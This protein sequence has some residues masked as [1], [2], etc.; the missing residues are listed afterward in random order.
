MKRH[1]VLTEEGK[2]PAGTH[3]QRFV[4]TKDDALVVV[5]ADNIKWIREAVDDVQE[6]LDELNRR[7]DSVI[8]ETRGEVHPEEDDVGEDDVG[9]SVTGE[10]DDERRGS[11]EKS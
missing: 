4:V 2:S 10:G 9:G 6:A 7:V 3:R 1:Y 5:E 11:E 8:S